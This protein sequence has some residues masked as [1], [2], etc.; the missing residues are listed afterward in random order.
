M[1]DVLFCFFGVKIVFCLVW[2]LAGGSGLSVLG[3]SSSPDE[4][5][6]SCNVKILDDTD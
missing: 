1:S 2:A 3:L 5:V 6:L 4:Q